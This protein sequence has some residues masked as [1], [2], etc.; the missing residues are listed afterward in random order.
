MLLLRRRELFS[1][2]AEPCLWFR[3]GHANGASKKY[4]VYRG[5]LA[6]PAV[7]VGEDAPSI[8]RVF[9]GWKWSSESRKTI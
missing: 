6:E 5:F 2:P 4:D 1:K 7:R 8:Q 9:S 3:K